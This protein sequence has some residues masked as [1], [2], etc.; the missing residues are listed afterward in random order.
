MPPYKALLFDPETAPTWS[1]PSHVPSLYPSPPNYGPSFCP[2]APYYELASAP[3]EG[4]SSSARPRT[5]QQQ[6]RFGKLDFFRG[7][8]QTQKTNHSV[9]GR[10][11]QGPM[12]ALTTQRPGNDDINDIMLI[13]KLV[14][15]PQFSLFTKTGISPNLHLHPWHSLPPP[16]ILSIHY[17]CP[18]S[19]P[20][21]T[22][23]HNLVHSLPPPT[24]LSVH[25]LPPTSLSVHYFLSVRS[26]SCR[27]INPSKACPPTKLLQKNWSSLLIR[28]KT[29]PR[30][31]TRTTAP[32][33]WR[34]WGHHWTLCHTVQTC[35]ASQN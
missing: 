30:L 4:S 13:L 28:T 32:L 34:G 8:G 17:L 6:P 16:T 35:S 1:S 11:K 10:S 15:L 2:T 9:R 19:C 22:S 24:F 26:K 31:R 20:F 27:T 7:L 18:Q 33:T 25:Y 23:A 29:N 5:S 12:V 21:I 3:G 14:S